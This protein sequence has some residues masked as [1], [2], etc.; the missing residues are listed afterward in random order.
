MIQKGH[1]QVRKWKLIIF[2]M[3]GTLYDLQDVAGM[4]Y[5]ME[6]EFYSTARGLPEEEAES[7][8]AANSILSYAS[9]KAHSASS[10]PKVV[11]ISLYG[12]N[13]ESG[14]LTLVKLIC[15]RLLAR[16]LSGHSVSMV[17]SFY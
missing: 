9:E 14:A 12:R 2:D 3:D 17:S 1:F 16:K 6:V 7:V 8:L 5:R 4:N 10:F 15:I 11:W 13:F